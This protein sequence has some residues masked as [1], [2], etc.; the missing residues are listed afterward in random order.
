MKRFIAV[1]CSALFAFWGVSVMRTIEGQ[2]SVPWLMEAVEFSM[3]L[4]GAPKLLLLC[5]VGVGISAAI[6]VG[7]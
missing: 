4:F 2:V 3:M 6:Y 5:G 7:D 1:T